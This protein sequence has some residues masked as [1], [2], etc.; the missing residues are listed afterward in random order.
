[1]GLIAGLLA[2]SLTNLGAVVPT[3]TVLSNSISQVAAAPPAG[4]PAPRHAFISSRTLTAAENSAPLDFEVALKMRNFAELQ[5][6]VHR[7]DH[8]SRAEMAAKY[9]PLPA[10]Y[11]AAVD[12]L[13]GEGFTITR[14]DSRHMLIFVRGEVSRVARSMKVSFA[15]VTS[16]GKEYSSAIT[17]PSVPANISPF[18]IGINGLQ[19]HLRMHKHLLKQQMHPDGAVGS[20]NYLPRQIAQ[21]YGASALY[22]QNL[23]G[24]GQTIAIVIDTFPSTT[25]LL[26][27]W[28][29]CSISQSISNI[30]FIQAVKGTL[31]APSGEETLDVEWS[32]AMAPDAHVRVYAATDLATNHLDEAYTQI[33]DDAT[34]HP[35]YGIH[36]MSMSYGEGETDFSADVSPPNNVPTSNSQL[37]T[38]DALFAE[39]AAAGVTSFASSGDGGNSPGSGSA[40]DKSGPVQVESPASDPNVTGVGGTSL[41]LDSNNNISSETVWNNSSGATGGGT[42]IYFARPS[43]QQGTGVPSGTMREVP[44]ICAAADPN[45]GAIIYEDGNESVVGGTSWSS[46]MW[47]GFCALMNQARANAGLPSL[48]IL[49]SHD[50]HHSGDGLGA[51]IYSLIGTSNFHDIVSGNNSTNG[52]TAFNAQS[53]Y[54]L[55]TGIGS[56]VMQTL[57]GTVLRSSAL[58]GLKAPL[59]EQAIPP[60][61]NATFA[62][63]VSGISATYQWQRKPAGSTTWSNLSDDSTY[64]GSTSALLAVTGATTAMSGDQFQCLVTFGGTTTVTTRASVLSV[65][66]TLA[67]STLA[68]SAGTSGL[69]DGTQTSAQFSY[70]S[71]V[72]LDS[73]G[74]IYVADFK[75]N[76][77]RKVTS[78]GTVTTPYGSTIGTA[79]TTNGNGNNALFN[80]PNS[81]ANDG[82]DNFYVADTG[83]N[84]IREI[85]SSGTVS[86]VGAGGQFNGPSSVAVDGS[87]N[88]YVA[89]TGNNTIR[90][91][92]GGV[93]STIAGRKGTAGFADGN[94]TTQALLN[95][96][97]AVAVDGSGNVYVADFG[98]YAV[99]KISGGVVS[100]IAG[101]SITNA[102]GKIG[103]GGYLD[104]PGATALF[105]GPIGLALDS[106]NNLYVTDCLVPP[107][108]GAGS[109][110]A[111]NNLLR[112]ITPAGIVTT[113]AGQAGNEGTANGT[114]NVAQ[115]YSL[116]AVAFNPQN[117]TFYLADTYNQTIRMAVP[118]TPP[119]ISI[120][121]TQPN[122]LVFGPTPGQFTVTRSGNTSNAVTVN[123][124]VGGTAGPGTDYTT[125]S[126]MLTIPI[127]ATSALIS[128]NP[129]SN[130]SATSPTLQITLA[131]GA[132][133]T[134][135]SPDTATMTIT[136]MTPFQT[137]ETNEFP[138]QTTDP[139]VVGEMSDPNH[140]GVPNLLEYAFNSNPLQPGTEPLP[141]L[142]TV[143]VNGLEYLAL[144]FTE[145][146][147]DPN[148]IYTVQVTGDLTQQTDVWNSNTTVVSQVVNGNTTQMT[149]RDNTAISP[150]TKRFIRVQI[151]GN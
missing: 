115:F 138:G 45:F 5:A 132:G 48:G 131:S 91:I 150:T 47:A 126:G 121:T 46:P 43:W 104:G 92:A 109:G 39:L 20:A 95:A 133:Y 113:L 69:Q 12:W 52:N 142:S 38:D 139:T 94:A 18:L 114:G 124:T 8:V 56:P 57:V 99:R 19:P 58:V 148:L 29:N 116:Q 68:G 103:V 23:S 89:D 62:V 40:G 70:P 97:A 123:Y 74:N 110:G 81:I 101:Q 22:Q 26:L 31:P 73:A 102:S 17:A 79:G 21:A 149:V 96:P 75:N 85:A 88:V 136:E 112:K 117:D 50:A 120:A 143:Q 53:G 36:Q 84:L 130:P 35:E 4:A 14:Q 7:G 61:A 77:I 25:D 111:G 129:L 54:D 145:R 16:E 3:T 122:A 107:T 140:N 60:G 34:N 83:N 32:S 141:V 76:N 72:A 63:T 146:N 27:F 144:T 10:D 151:T 100:T 90:K 127:G 105:N 24:A 42:S 125:L 137:W 64:S 108:S 135:G 119:T 41:V 98:N 11:Q 71:G 128:V 59:A 147:D 55:D 67:V 9:E 66:S 30:E 106:S 15:R 1:M 51:S 87:G 65:E 37:N 78:T 33:L 6:R 118:T 44:D 80:T 86:T 28:K 134:V 82:S 13:T 49:G 93:V 2:V